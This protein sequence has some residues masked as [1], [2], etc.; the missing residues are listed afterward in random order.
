MNKKTCYYTNSFIVLL[1]SFQADLEQY[2]NKEVA[3]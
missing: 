3:I 1:Y 2:M